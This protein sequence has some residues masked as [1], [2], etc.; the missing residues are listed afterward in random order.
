MA[1]LAAFVAA[2]AALSAALG[3]PAR[4][5]EPADAHRSAE[6]AF[7]GGETIVPA[8]IESLGQEGEHY[9]VE[10]L[11]GGYEVIVFRAHVDGRAMVKVGG[12]HFQDGIPVWRSVL[13][14]LPASME[15]EAEAFDFA[16]AMRT[17]LEWLLAI[18]ALSGIDAEGIA[19]AA[20]KLGRGMRY[21]TGQ[22]L[23]VGMNCVAPE[24]CYRC[25]GSGSFT[26]LP[27]ASWDDATAVTGEAGWGHVKAATSPTQ[28]PGACPCDAE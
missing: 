14:V 21:F 8:A 5:C 11:E 10:R 16:G 23:Q 26:A 6:V 1:R 24:V 9:L 4:A 18:G 25:T 27:P 19:A 28:H 7:T 12:G 15:A 20:E 3:S 17:E 22:A 13:V 2:A